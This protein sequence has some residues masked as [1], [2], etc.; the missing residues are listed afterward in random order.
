MGTYKPGLLPYPSLWDND[1]AGSNHSTVI[2][3]LPRPGL[4]VNSLWEVA[5]ICSITRLCMFY[6]E[7]VSSSCAKM[8]LENKR[9]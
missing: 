9:W 1:K 2:Q 3:H 5:F 6:R 7:N 8:D 4:K